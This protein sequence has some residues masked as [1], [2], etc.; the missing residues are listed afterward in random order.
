MAAVIPL[1]GRV[2]VT[3]GTGTVRFVGQTAF[4]AGK[5]VG[6]QLDEPTGKNDGSVAGTRY[7]TCADGYGVFVR[8]SM[9][10]VLDQGGPVAEQVTATRRPSCVSCFNTHC[11]VLFSP[12]DPPSFVCLCDDETESLPRAGDVRPCSDS[13][14]LAAAVSSLVPCIDLVFSQPATFH[15]ADETA[16][17]ARPVCRLLLSTRF[18]RFTNS[19][20]HCRKAHLDAPAADPKNT[21]RRSS[22]THSKECFRSTGNH[23]NGSDHPVDREKGPARQL[24][25]T[26][27]GTSFAI[28]CYWKRYDSEACAT[29]CRVH[30][31]FRERGN[32]SSTSSVASSVASTSSA[33]RTQSATE[34]EA[35][36]GGSAPGNFVGDDQDD[37][38]SGLGTIR[39]TK[40]T[41]Q[42]FQKASI[43]PTAAS[44]PFSLRNTEQRRPLEA[45]VPQRAYDELAAKLSIVERRRAEDRDKLRDLDRLIEEQGEWNRV[46]EK[47]KARVAELTGEVKELKRENKDLLAERDSVQ[48]KF[49]DLQEQVEHSLLDKEIAESELEDVQ[50]RVKE[51]EEQLGE[52]QVEM[53]VVKE[54]NARL[55]GLGDAEIAQARDAEAGAGNGTEQSGSTAPSSLAFRQLEKQN[56]RLKEALLRLRDLTS[57]N[58]NEMKRKIENLEKEVDLTTDLQGD[59]DNMAVELDAAEAKIEDLRSQLDIAAEAQDMLEELTERNMHLQDDNEALRVDVEELE[60]LKELADELEESHA[61]TEKQ[62]QEELDLRDLQLQE[63]RRRCSLLEDNC[64]D[65]ETTIGQ[66]R[67]LVISLQADLEQLRQ[68]QATQETESQ[69]L[70]SQSQAMLNLNLKLQSTVLK[71]QVKAID[72]ELRELE[73]RQAAEHFA[74][75]KPYLPAAFFESDSDAVD[76]LLFFERVGEKVAL[77]GRYIE[78]KH[79]VGEA[80]DGTVPDDLIGICEARSK[81][82]HF[83]AL[84]KRFSAHLRRCPP[85]TFLKMGSV[86]REVASTEKRI[87]AYVEAL[88][89]EELQEISCAK[90]LEGIIAQTEH[91]A[92]TVLRDLDPMLDLFERESA[93]VGSLDLDL[94]TIAVAAGF[95]KQTVAAISREPVELGGGDL[96]DAIFKPLQNLVNYSRNAKVLIKKMRRRLDEL[97][98]AGSA[99]SLEHAQGLETLAFNS[100]AIASAL[101]KLAADVR[102]YCGEV[103][104]SKAPLQLTT[105]H[106]IAK[107]IAAVE[108]GKQSP[109]PLDEVNALLVQLVQDMSTALSTSLESEHVVKLSYAAPWVAR[110]AALQSKAAIDVDAERDVARLTEEVRTMSHAMRTK[111]QLY[112]ESLV[113]IEI[114]EKRLEGVKKQAEAMARLEAELAKSRRQERTYEEANEVLQRDLDNMERELDKVK[115]ATTA[116]EKQGAVDQTTTYDPTSGISHHESNLETSYLLERISSLRSAVR[117]LRSENAFLKS[118]DLV[119]DLDALPA[120]GGGASHRLALDAHDEPHLKSAPARI[121]R[122]EVKTTLARSAPPLL[123]ASSRRFA[124]TTFCGA[125]L[126]PNNGSIRLEYAAL[127]TQQQ[128]TGS[129]EPALGGEGTG[130]EVGMEGGAAAGGSGRRSRLSRSSPCP[131]S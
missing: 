12:A 91:L 9:V 102:H 78:Q 34:D 88:R 44:D 108:L 8:A 43:L 110:V 21:D 119:S 17:I 7:F 36:G 69:N 15:F 77:L 76:A 62:L 28:A 122:R 42:A 33:R 20:G 10:S 83:A 114:L 104:S 41:G 85:A 58:E 66:F 56:A 11:S 124:P 123:H 87:D 68:H 51:L 86:Y 46:K 95:A 81:L 29:R 111:E 84:N 127:D 82:D 52:V 5:W 38:D 130:E 67:E 60:A 30:H 37:D 109:R 117:F 129:E 89:R 97:Q 103:R 113:K 24:C 61:E 126:E 106:G 107:E 6:I 45:T 116:A 93:C 47:T 57:E 50:A 65:Y 39:A 120:G 96:D 121:V 40:S 25:T 54:E 18:G 59:L 72:L 4:A 63:I 1:N 22:T 75:V 49:D 55:E 99:A 32:L 73:A 100:S 105:L 128:A 131:S 3:A 23:N 101:S 112:Q 31:E 94:D 92:E 53:E 14:R 27:C 16:T 74:I 125:N 48:S 13:F 26:I 80:L 64:V 90:D 115:Q 35:D 71:S 98:T 118:H 79:T 2:Q 70:T 19:N